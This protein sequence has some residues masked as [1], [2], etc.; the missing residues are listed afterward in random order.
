MSPRAWW[1]AGLPTLA[2][3]ASPDSFAAKDKPTD[4]AS[5]PIVRGKYAF[6]HLGTKTKI[7][8]ARAESGIR[9]EAA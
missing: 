2:A 4:S 8:R 1:E 6:L 9:T 3:R 7:T 5:E